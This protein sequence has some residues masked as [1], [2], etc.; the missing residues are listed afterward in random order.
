MNSIKNSMTA[1]APSTFGMPISGITL[2]HTSACTTAVAT[3][4]VRDRKAVKGA[5]QGLALGYFPGTNAWRP[6]NC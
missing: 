5:D 3:S 1:L 4:A 6:P 2:G